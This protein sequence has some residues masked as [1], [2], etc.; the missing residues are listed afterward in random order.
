MKFIDIDGTLMSTR[1]VISI[2][3]AVIGAVVVT[4][5]YFILRRMEAKHEEKIRQ[6]G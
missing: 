1:S 4:A 2:D 3:L 5:G 6:Q